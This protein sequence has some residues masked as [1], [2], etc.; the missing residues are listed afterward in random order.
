[1]P[2]FDFTAPDGKSYSVDGP[3]GATSAQAF[4]KLQ[5]HLGSSAPKA[6]APAMSA[7][8]VAADVAKSGSVGVV[9]GGIGIAGM[10]GLASDFL[11]RAS[12][13]ATNFIADKIG[14]DRGPQ[15]GETLLPTA[16]S[17]N[18]FIG[19]NPKT[20]SGLMTDENGRN[21]IGQALD[22][23][24]KTK[25]GE[26]AQTAGEFLPAVVGGPETLAAKLFSRVAVPALVSETAGQMTKGTAAEPYAR[27]AAAFLSPV[28]A[29]RSA[30]RGTVSAV[31]S[32]DEILS[33][34]GKQFNAARDMNVIVKP[35]FAT[36]AAA[37]MRSAVKN[38]DPNVIKDV[39][40]A[41]DRL[42]AFGSPPTA[43]L[44]PAQRLQAEMNWEP[45]PPVK[46]TPVAMN[47][48][49]NIRKQLVSLKTS[50]DASVRSAA[51]DAIKSL[52]RSQMTL[53]PADT[54]S[55]DA[56]AYRNTVSDAVGNWAAGK[57]SNTVTGKV[58]LAEL[59]SGTAG[60]GANEDNAL[61][62]A[63]KQLARPINNTNVPVATKL[64]FNDP[65]IAAIRQAATGTPLGN[66]ARYIGKAAPTGIVPAVMGAGAGGMAGGLPGA[67]ALPAVG[68]IAKKIGDLST[69]Q[70]VAS[71]DS[72]V[73]SRSPLSRGNAGVNAVSNAL[74]PPAVARPAGSRS[75]DAVRAALLAASAPR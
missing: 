30:A 42:E 41:A 67:V 45:S 60:S 58:D 11:A 28:A 49:E 72:M 18:H 19:D 73:R 38:Y 15:V 64:G 63:I 37:D 50:P 4:Q 16:A 39:R 43:A 9:K 66:A 7:G 44:S 68:Y 23:K 21:A 36:N 2:T 53:T 1:M 74:F 10:P 32:A 75:F 20:L 62:Q 12:Q 25:W 22:Y 46:T 71:I 35:D 47:D 40:A 6:A 24:P 8:D 59:N 14:I 33:T 61:R 5:Q 17:I 52:Q 56:A 51:S 70:A 31:P 57:R 13:H 3:E 27:T 55:G 54:L 26:Y 34:A 29:A 69:K 48:T 65:E